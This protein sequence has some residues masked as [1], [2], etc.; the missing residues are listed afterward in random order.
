MVINHG[1]G[2][3]IALCN[4]V[5]H[6][7]HQEL[8]LGVISDHVPRKPNI[9]RASDTSGL[10]VEPSCFGVINVTCNIRTYYMPHTS[11]C[12]HKARRAVKRYQA[13]DA[14]IMFGYKLP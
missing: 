4:V 9:K 2:K 3:Q 6:G 8:T 5:K 7:S 14:D 12:I 13:A 1:N 10:R 11:L